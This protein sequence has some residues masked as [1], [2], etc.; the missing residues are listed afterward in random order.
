MFPRTYFNGQ[1]FAPRYFEGP[2]GSRFP[3][4][5]GEPLSTQCAALPFT[6]SNSALPLSTR[7]TSLPT[8]TE[9]A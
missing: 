3:D 4:D 2:G 1:Y 6:T 8:T 9:P 7:S 5:M